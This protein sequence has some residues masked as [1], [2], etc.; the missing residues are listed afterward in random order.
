MTLLNRFIARRS[1]IL[2]TRAAGEATPVPDQADLNFTELN[3]SGLDKSPLF[4]ER[5]RHERFS[6]RF[7]EGHRCFGFVASDGTPLS[8]LWLTR[9]DQ[10]AR[11]PIGL[12]VNLL[13]GTDDAYIW[14]CRTDQAAQGRGLY[15]DGL[16]HLA[17]LAKNEA[18]ANVWIDCAPDNI[19]SR[20][21]IA[22]AGFHQST[23]WA[24]LRAGDLIRFQSDG[25]RTRFGFS[26][27]AIDLQALKT[28]SAFTG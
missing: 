19:A 6:R 11:I 15:R 16:R 3:P 18:A 17:A 22:A 20:A 24:I 10:G 1:A 25:K 4:S 26:S 2:F 9:R 27:L 7:T 21:G 8:Y 5:G 13:P 14:D 12:G 28:H 23:A